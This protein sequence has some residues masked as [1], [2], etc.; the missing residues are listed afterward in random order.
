MTTLAAVEASDDVAG[1]DSAPVLLTVE[2]AAR[3]LRIGRTTC[4]RLVLS[5]EIESVTVGR[6]RRIP[7]DALTAY[8]AKL[9]RPAVAA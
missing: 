4:F 5:G 7:V 8:V 6:L 1:A 9:R 3:R 2:E